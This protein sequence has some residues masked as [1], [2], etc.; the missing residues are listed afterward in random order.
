M[1]ITIRDFQSIARADLD[2]DGLTVIVGQSNRGKS[3][4]IRAVEGALF[5]RPGDGFVRIGAKSTEVAVTL[6]SVGPD[7]TAPH[8]VTWTKGGGV[9]AFEVDGQAYG[10]VGQKA[11]DVL[12]ALGFRDAQIGG[13]VKEETGKLE[14]AETVRPQVAHQFDPIFLLDR[15]GSFL[16]EVMVKLS[17]LEVLQ[18]ANRACSADLRTAK[19][20]VSVKAADLAKANALVVQMQAV[21]SLRERVVGLVE[22][23]GQLRRNWER[24]RALKTLRDQYALTARAAAS[25]LPVRAPRTLPDYDRLLSIES[26][27]VQRVAVLH[28]IVKLPKRPKPTKKTSEQVKLY[29]QL[30]PLQIDR[31]QHVNW[32]DQYTAEADRAGADHDTALQAFDSLK[33]SLR[34]CPTCERPF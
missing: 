32:V 18:R 9:N 2:V 1:K 25:S 24:L 29:L 34:V 28:R 22:R 26:L 6:P 3:A 23:Q 30:Q 10:R 15:P 33:Q 21:V 20:T 27:A 5:N 14:G 19:S 12:Y 16:N 4:A 11:P 8:T 17:R 13:R 31:R 7:R